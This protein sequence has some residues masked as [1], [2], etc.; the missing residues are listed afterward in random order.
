M[1]MYYKIYLVTKRREKSLLFSL[2]YGSDKMAS[3]TLS[4]P[5]HQ[6]KGSTQP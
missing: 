4:H 6:M 3:S 5:L 2:F 1:V